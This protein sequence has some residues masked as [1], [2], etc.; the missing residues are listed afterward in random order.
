M[1]EFNEI[2]NQNGKK[3]KQRNKDILSSVR[4]TD[5]D[6]IQRYVNKNAKPLSAH[7]LI[8]HIY[9]NV[10][11]KIKTIRPDNEADNFTPNHTIHIQYINHHFIP[12]I[13]WY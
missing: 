9:D 2:V 10:F 4:A 12:L 1:K 7:K 8:I 11:K 3:I 6:T 13:K 5:E